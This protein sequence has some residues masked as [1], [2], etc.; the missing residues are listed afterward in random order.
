[1]PKVTFGRR[2][3]ANQIRENPRI[4]GFLKSNDSR[5]SKTIELKEGTPSEVVQEVRGEAADSRKGEAEKFGQVALTESER[6][7][8]DFT[9]TSIPEARSAKAIAQGKGVDDFTSYFDPELS[10]DEHREVF[11]GA[12]RD[13]RGSRGGRGRDDERE[14]QNRLARGHNTIKQNRLPRAKD[15]AFSGD[16]EAQGFVREQVEAGESYDIEFSRGAAGPVE[17]AGEDFDR[18]LDVH[19]SRSERAQALDERMSAPNTRDPIE[20]VN[21]MER[22][23]FPGIDTIDPLDLHAQRPDHARAVDERE[24]APIAD[25]KEQWALNPDQFDLEDI[26][27]PDF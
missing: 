20:W 12:V 24:L 2:E 13:E 26:D 3:I 21:N 16:V 17:G 19:E 15:A 7:R 10:V 27:T 5:R 9:K 6:E 1:M 14:F 22:M 4:R 18:L 8:I 23:D 25:T 11:T